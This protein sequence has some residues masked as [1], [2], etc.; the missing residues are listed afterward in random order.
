MSRGLLRVGPAPL[1]DESASLRVVVARSARELAPYEAAWQALAGNALEPNSF[2]EPWAVTPALE[3]L[4]LRG[5]P[6]VVLVVAPGPSPRLTGV[7]PLL[8]RARWRGLPLPV[9]TSFDH[10]F[11]FLQTPLVGARDADATLEAFA[12]W[13][14]TDSGAAL[15]ALERLAL[16]GPFFARMTGVLR[17]RAQALHI[18]DCY[19][20][21]VLP[22]PAAGAGVYLDEALSP[23]KRKELRR[24]EKRLAEQGTLR[25]V[26]SHGNGDTVRLV[27]R[28][29]E[30]EASGWKGREGTALASSLPTR[31]FFEA[32]AQGAARAGRLHVLSLELDGRAIAMQINFVAPPGSYS[33]KIAYDEALGGFSPGVLLEPAVEWMD[34]CAVSDH[35]LINRL[36]LHRRTL[37]TVL[38]STGHAFG[39]VLL[40]ALPLARLARRA[41]RAKS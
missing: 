28:F 38:V 11:A 2:Y 23:K 25:A 6:W 10:D 31:R 14:R 13:L 1:A 18:D 9:L 8:R 35:A 37:G 34:S 27:R 39:D 26:A 22:R 29:L 4:A 33:F 15:L 32:L 40:A 17:R 24:L 19:P 30:L 3:H 12:E 16:D 7:F 36:W 41:L 20:R 5:E 21:A